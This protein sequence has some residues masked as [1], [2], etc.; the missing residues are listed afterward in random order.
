MQLPEKAAMSSDASS[1]RE[2]PFEVR[3]KIFTHWFGKQI[4]IA[5]L[6]LIVD[7]DGSLPRGRKLPKISA[8]GRRQIAFL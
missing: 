7:H 4:P 1:G 2:L 6:H 8:V 3:V 5:S